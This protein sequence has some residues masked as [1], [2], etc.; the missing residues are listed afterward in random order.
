MNF[1]IGAPELQQRPVLAQHRIAFGQRHFGDGRQRLVAFGRIVAAAEIVGAFRWIGA[2]DEK[3]I[4]GRKPL[5]ARA[6]R[7]HDD[8]AGLEFKYFADMSAELDSRMAAG[9]AERFVIIE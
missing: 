4:A 2:D 7:Q 1:F 3:I 9:D 5:M 6:R 8:I